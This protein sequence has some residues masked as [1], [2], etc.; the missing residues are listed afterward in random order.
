MDTLLSIHSIT[1]VYFL[2]DVFGVELALDLGELD[3]LVADRHKASHNQSKL[4]IY[5]IN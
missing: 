2:G 4:Y 5:M 3:A 1:N